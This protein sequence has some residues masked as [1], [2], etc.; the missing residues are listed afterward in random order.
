MQFIGYVLCRIFHEGRRNR[1]S[2]F[3]GI[4]ALGLIFSTNPCKLNGKGW[5]VLFCSIP[6]FQA[7]SCLFV[8]PHKV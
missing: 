2:E 5:V 1:S 7:I 8:S 4:A 3:S 6:L